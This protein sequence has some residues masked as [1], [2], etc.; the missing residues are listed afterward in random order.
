MASE[1][2]TTIGFLPPLFGANIDPSARDPQGPFRRAQLADEHGLDLIGVQD[3]PYNSGFLETWTLLTALGA[4]TR[5]VR[6]ITNVLNTPLRLPA[7]IAKQAATLDV[8]IGGRVELGLGAGA[9]AQGIIAYG[10]VAREPAEALAAFEDTI[11]I[12][13]GMLD[14]AGGTFSYSGRVHQVRG[15]RPGPAPAHRVPIWTGAN[16]PRGLRLTGRLADGVLLSSTYVSPD[17]LLENNR[18]IDEGAAQ[19]GRPPTAIRR[20]YNLMGVLDLGRPGTRIEQPQ[21]G[22]IVGPPQH[23]I[24]TIVRFYRDYRQ[25]TFMF[26]PIGGDELA[27]VEA[28]AREVAPAARAAIEGLRLPVSS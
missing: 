27:Q 5:R 1:Q 26:W 21:P 7:M 20:G 24:E 13:R 8:L 19:A 14:S 23:W 28:F 3:H 2:T 4:A 6:L 22:Q 16:R 18:L 12:V 11:Q 15:A 17:Q 25:D 9:F 10:G